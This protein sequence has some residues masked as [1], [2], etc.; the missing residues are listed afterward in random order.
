MAWNNF[1]FN[2]NC[3]IT[4]ITSLNQNQKVS[5]LDDYEIDYRSIIVDIYVHEDY[6]IREK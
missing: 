2:I 3:C 4:F 1:V 5:L 6:F